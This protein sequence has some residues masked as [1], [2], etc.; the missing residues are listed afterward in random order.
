MAIPRIVPQP[1]DKQLPVH[2]KTSVTLHW[3]LFGELEQAK[4]DR[5]ITSVV[6]WTLQALAPL[7]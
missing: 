6:R 2:L 4:H 5:I 1:P 3:A 7:L